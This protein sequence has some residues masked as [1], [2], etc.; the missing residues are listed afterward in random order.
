MGCGHLRWDTLSSCT[1][2]QKRF[3]LIPG[4]LHEE[5]NM[6]KAYVELNWDID[7]RDFAQCQ[8]IELRINYSSLKNA[9]IIISHGM[10]YVI[11]I[12]MQWH[13]N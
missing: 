2:D 10:L 11:Y 5:M 3:S 6:L 4:A 9:W 12:G 7:I 13:L 1:K 8:G